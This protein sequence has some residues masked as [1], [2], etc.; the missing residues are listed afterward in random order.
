MCSRKDSSCK[1]QTWLCMVLLRSL[2]ERCRSYCLLHG[3]SDSFEDPKR[4]ALKYE[5]QQR[6]WSEGP[7][8][9]LNPFKPDGK[10]KD[11]D[12]KG[13]SKG[14]G[15]KGKRGR[16]QSASKSD[17][18]GSKDVECF[19]C[20]KKGHFAR[21]CWAPAKKNDGKDAP[22]QKSG[23]KPS[24]RGKAKAKGGKEKGKGKGKTVAEVANGE[25]DSVD[26]T[27][28][29]E[30]T[31]P[32]AEAHVSSVLQQLNEIVEV[33]RRDWIPPAQDEFVV[34]R[35]AGFQVRMTELEHRI[36][37]D[38]NEMLGKEVPGSVNLLRGSQVN[39]VSSLNN[40]QMSNWWLIFFLVLR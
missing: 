40:D 19:N 7:G 32:E 5:V 2:P 35:E 39:G 14:K 37:S 24:P 31:E 12:E 25:G 1:K 38:L 8:T 17:A 34:T 15:K 3:D 16:S 20:G 11:G 10:G 23:G 9:K 4:V 26:L 33:V 21:D 22:N 36:A 29:Q 18:K 13:A 28:N 27:G 6:V 30:W